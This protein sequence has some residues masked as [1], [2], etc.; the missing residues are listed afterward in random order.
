MNPDHLKLLQRGVDAWNA[1]R[2][3]QASSVPDLSGADLHGVNLHEANF[4]EANLSGA[5]LS[6]ANLTGANL[7]EAKMPSPE[8]PSSLRDAASK[9]AA[10]LPG[11]WLSGKWIETPTGAYHGNCKACL[12]G[13]AV[14]I[15]GSFGPELSRKLTRLG[16]TIRWNDSSGRTEA[17][18]IAALESIA[19]SSDDTQR[20][21][22]QDPP[23]TR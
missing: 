3:K 23:G 13:A 2:V 16:Y 11:H 5:D 21:V 22:L 9:V 1:W 14:Y 10:W 18:V 20:C 17:D 19:E 8:E 4:Y 6:G 12:H 15:G 7:I